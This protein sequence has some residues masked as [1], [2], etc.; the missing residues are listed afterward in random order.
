MSQKDSVDFDIIVV[1]CG[2]A[3]L[4]AASSALEYAESVGQP[5]QVVSVERASPKD[6]GGNSR[7]SNCAMMMKDEKS[8]APNFEKDIMDRSSGKSDSEYVHTLALHAAETV[9]WLREKGVDFIRAT[10]EHFL[11]ASIPYISPVGGGL[12]IITAL[13]SHAESL[14][15]QIAYQ[16]AAWRLST[17]EQ[18]RV[19]GVFVRE[20]DSIPVK[21][22]GTAV[23]LATGGFQGNPEMLS[24][25]IGEWAYHLHQ[26]SEG[27]VF[28]KGEGI[29]MARALGGRLSGQFNFFHS[30]PVDPRSHALFPVVN[31]FPYGI[32]VN[33]LG[34]RFVDE[35]LDT[36]DVTALELGERILEQP[37]HRAFMIA[38]QQLKSIRGWQKAVKSDQPPIEAGSLEELAQR[39]GVPKDRLLETVS[40]YNLAVRPGDFDPFRKDGKSTAGLEPAKSNWAIP[41]SEGPFLCYPLVC[42]ILFTCGGLAVDT[43]GR[44][45][46]EDGL[47]LEGL[48]AAGE[49]TG[50]YYHKYPSATSMLRALVFGRIAGIH[51]AKFVLDG[52]RNSS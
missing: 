37:G 38:D 43:S 50:L 34:E 1:G 20:K 5:L 23:V 30:D 40:D 13:K 8:V 16:S 45:I 44:V 39:I 25:Y 48:Y 6:W 46:S 36:V 12:T 14:G 31:V 42:G 19:D 17:D 21:T 29:E 32:V 22:K 49:V 51:A 11:T 35:G 4:A 47:P 18:G 9:S 52:K 24:R 27:G 7:W 41:I 15:L 33:E 2:A 10:P 3:G 28:D 26:V